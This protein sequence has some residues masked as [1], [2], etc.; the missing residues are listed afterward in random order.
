MRARLVSY[1]TYKPAGVPWLSDVPQHWET[2][3]GRWMF[4]KM[5]RRDM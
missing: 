5:D 1:P 2:R 3:R 4:R